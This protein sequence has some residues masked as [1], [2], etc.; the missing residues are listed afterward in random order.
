MDTKYLYFNKG[1]F[2]ALIRLWRK[3]VEESGEELNY[4]ETLKTDDELIELYIPL[5][6]INDINTLLYHR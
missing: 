5:K 2:K 1:T 4:L 3:V 6:F